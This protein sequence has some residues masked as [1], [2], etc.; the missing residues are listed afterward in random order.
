MARPIGALRSGV[1]SATTAE[2][3]LEYSAPDDIIGP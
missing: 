2:L 1:G 3:E